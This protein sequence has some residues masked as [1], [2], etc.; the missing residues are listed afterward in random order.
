MDNLY[1]VM[2]LFTAALVTFALRF[3]PSILFREGRIPRS[4]LRIGKVLPEAMMAVLVVYCLKDA[5][6]F[7]GNYA[8]PE[9]LGIFS[10]IAIYLW[11]RNVLL[12]IGVSTFFYMVLVQVFF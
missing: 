3:V 6:F 2:A 8:L 11:R 10:C 4:F 5:Q 9:I 12:S 7:Y 1:F